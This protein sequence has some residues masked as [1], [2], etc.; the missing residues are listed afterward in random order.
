MGL[1]DYTSRYPVGK[2]QPP[3]Y[4]Y[5]HFLVA[6]ID[7]FIACLKFQD[8]ASLNLEMNSIP[9]GVLNTQKL[10]RNENDISSNSLETQNTFTLNSQ[11]TNY[12]RS[13]PFQKVENLE[14]NCTRNSN[15]IQQ[16]EY[17][18]NRQTNTA[19]RM[20]LPPFQQILLKCYK[21]AQT[22][23]SFHPKNISSFDTY[24][25]LLKDLMFSDTSHEVIPSEDSLTFRRVPRDQACQTN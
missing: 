17:E 9:Y 25:H 18:M 14:I 12:S 21:G 20:P 16:S 24:K 15:D 7:D 5:G 19:S 10:D 6:L 13:K 3:A 23:I 8:S 4:W 1:V 2:F 22:T 11:Q